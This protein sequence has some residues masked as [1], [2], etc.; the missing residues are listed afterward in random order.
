MGWSATS[1]ACDVYDAWTATC[2]AQTGIQNV[3][4]D[5]DGVE[6]FIETGREQSDGAI[7]GTVHRLD[8]GARSGSFRIEPD[9]A[10]TRRPPAFP[11]EVAAR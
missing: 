4:R 9:G 6:R 8:T 10:V 5:A 1:A 11:R 7:V 3:Y 2:V